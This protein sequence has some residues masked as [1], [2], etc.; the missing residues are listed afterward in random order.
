MRHSLAQPLLFLFIFTSYLR[1]LCLELSSVFKTSHP[2][3]YLTF[4]GDDSLASARLSDLH[5]DFY[6]LEAQS[7][8]FPCS[9]V[10][11]Y[12]KDEVQFYTLH[13]VV[14]EGRMVSSYS[15]PSATVLKVRRRPGSPAASHAVFRL[16]STAV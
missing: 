4:K 15:R 12:G 5:P 1:C 9:T 6:G 13:L 11:S 8:C 10:S 2:V 7:P 16:K 3:K 14:L